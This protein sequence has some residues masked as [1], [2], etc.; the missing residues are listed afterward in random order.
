MTTISLIRLVLISVLMSGVLAESAASSADQPSY[1]IGVS[2]VPARQ[3]VKYEVAFVARF[4]NRIVVDIGVSGPSVDDSIVGS[5][6]LWDKKSANVGRFDANTRV[7]ERLKDGDRRLL[8][9]TYTFGDGRDSL[10]ILGTGIY[11]GNLGLLNQQ[12]TNNFSIVGGTGKFLAAGGQC[13]ITRV[14]RIDYSVECVAF[15]PEY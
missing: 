6:T 7:S 10:V 14:D 9:V 3:P 8:W 13:G 4:D 2:D 1:V 5:G 15:V 11:T 12:V